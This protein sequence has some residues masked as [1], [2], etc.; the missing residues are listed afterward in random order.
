MST[1]PAVFGLCEADV[2][3]IDRILREHLPRE[4]RVWAFGSRARGTTKTHADLDLALRSTTPLPPL[5]LASLS[6]AFSDSDLPIRVD[7]VD[8]MGLSP[9]FKA[10][11]EDDLRVWPTSQ[12]GDFDA[13]MDSPPAR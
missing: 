7:V 9:A 10:S 8:L 5:L 11:I 2:A 3:L 6:S 4:T 12:T 13:Q 1:S